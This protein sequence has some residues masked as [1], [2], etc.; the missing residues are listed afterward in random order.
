MDHRTLFSLLSKAKGD[1]LMT[2]DNTREIASLAGE[3]GF[4]TQAIALKNTHH[5]KMTELLIGKN[6]SWLRTAAN[7]RE[8][9]ARSDQATLGFP[10]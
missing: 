2:Y 8:S 3:F 6:L 4:E 10:R 5:A 9:R 7:G 1:A